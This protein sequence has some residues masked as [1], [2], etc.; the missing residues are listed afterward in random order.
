MSQLGE[1]W[2]DADA[3]YRTI[4][5][6]LLP[7]LQRRFER[8]MADWDAL[9]SKALGLI[10]VAAAVIGGLAAAHHSINHLWAIPAGGCAVSGALLVGAVWPRV[11]DG[12]PDLIEIHDKMR[13]R[14]PLES[15]RLMFDALMD[16]NTQNEDVYGGKASW[17]EAGIALLALSIAATIPA[18]IFRP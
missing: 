4:S 1:E 13:A 8:T 14:G 17:Y 3:E 15:A 7:E 10:A 5:E 9:D 6:I 18:L 12:G 11:V 16:A 2:P